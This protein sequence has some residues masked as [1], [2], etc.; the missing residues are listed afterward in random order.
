[1]Q[2]DLWTARSGVSPLSDELVGLTVEGRDGTIGKVDHVSYEGTCVIVSTGRLLG[3]KYVIPAWAVERIDPDGEVVVD[4]T[5]DEVEGSPEYD[6]HA[7]FD[8]DCESRVGAYYED[9]M[10]T[11]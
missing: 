2:P 9:L 11:R 8:E 3:K 4:L 5:K 1:M 7:G 6:D 10:A